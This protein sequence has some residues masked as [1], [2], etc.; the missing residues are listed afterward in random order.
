M[1]TQ[2]G[3]LPGLPTYQPPPPPTLNGGLYGGEPF[4]PNAPWR[5][6]PQ[7]PDAGYQQT[8]TL[9][10]AE[11]PP[12]APYHIPGGGLRP[13]NNTPLLPQGLQQRAGGGL[14]LVCT[15]ADGPD[16]SHSNG[17]GF[18]RY[19]Y[20]PPPPCPPPPWR[21]MAGGHLPGG[22]LP[23]RGEPLGRAGAW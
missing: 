7:T 13:G 12:L 18:R 17:N 8:I 22:H 23:P 3:A 15:P 14:N 21:R 6:F 19:Y 2:P 10:S 16:L 11:P 5:N 9:R 4:P 1:Q 20:L